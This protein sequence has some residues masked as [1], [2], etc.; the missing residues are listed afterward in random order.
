[1]SARAGPRV[2]GGELA[3]DLERPVARLEREQLARGTRERA[4]ARGTSVR[5]RHD[6][7][8]CP[9][10]REREVGHARRVPGGEVLRDPPGGRGEHAPR[11]RLDAL[12]CRREREQ[13]DL[14]SLGLGEHRREPRAPLVSPV[15]EALGVELSPEE[16][17]EEM[18][19]E[20]RRDGYGYYASVLV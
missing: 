1:M 15:G 18:E 6:A 12:Q 7:Q 11:D 8:L 14:L 5:H 4:P 19:R 13:V 3:G 9:A 20:K 10:R 17:R 16:P 2:V